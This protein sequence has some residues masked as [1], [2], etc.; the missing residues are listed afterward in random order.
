MPF[1]LSVDPRRT[2][3]TAEDLEM[4]KKILCHFQKYF[5]GIKEPGADNSLTGCTIQ[6]YTKLLFMHGEGILE[7][8]PDLELVC[9]VYCF[10][11]L[12]FMNFP[13]STRNY[14][15]NHRYHNLPA[16]V[17]VAIKAREAKVGKKDIYAVMAYYYWAEMKEFALADQNDV[18]TAKCPIATGYRKGANHVFIAMSVK[19]QKKVLD[20]VEHWAKHGPPID[21]KIESV[22]YP[23]S[24]NLFI[25]LLLVWYQECQ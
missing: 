19:E 23:L 22:L 20:N 9:G 14:F 12:S 3:W 6:A 24:F 5:Q 11:L 13:Q 15:N 1:I 8:F 16:D 2:G 4:L 21:K 25:D 7:T 10:C 17:V 18:T